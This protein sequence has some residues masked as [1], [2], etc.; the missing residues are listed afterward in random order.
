LVKKLTTIN[1]NT[2]EK[3]KVKRDDKR[4]ELGKKNEVLQQLI[5]HTLEEVSAKTLVRK[6]TKGKKFQNWVT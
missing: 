6:L 4:I 3:D 1:I 5:I 2:L